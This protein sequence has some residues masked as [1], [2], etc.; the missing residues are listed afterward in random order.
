[1]KKNDTKGMGI[2]IP[3]RVRIAG[4]TFYVRD[5]QV[6]GRPAIQHE[7]RS[8]TFPQFVQRQKM[9]HA[10]AL[11][12]MLKLCDVMFTERKN[13]CLNFKSLA[14]QL[15]AVYVTKGQMDQASFLMPGIAMSD[16]ILPMVKQKLGEV[17]GTPA[18][19]TN[20]KAEERSEHVK[21]RLYTAVQTIESG[22]L[23]RVRFSMREV[24]W[25]DM[26]VVDG[27]LALVGEE[28]ADEM[29]GWA[30]VKVIDDRCSR[31]T[32]VTRCTL[33]Q[34]YTT[35]EALEEAAK[36]YGGLTKTPFLSPR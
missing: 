7:K 5:G 14:N 11:W 31:Q 27:H 16:G 18:L 32:I 17:N 10:I 13:A 30:L 26:T 3:K 6:V 34:Q 19:L 1:M 22:A 4:T 29:K 8:N 12:K 25:W 2:Q 20:L 33:Y 36:S 23:P 24:S 21:L 15:P 28:F 35:Q 9:R